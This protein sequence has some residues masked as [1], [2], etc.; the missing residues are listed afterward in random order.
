M[1]FALINNTLIDLKKIILFN[2]IN[3]WKIGCSQAS[4]RHYRQ[5]RS[6]SNFKYVFFE[7]IFHALSP[8]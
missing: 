6:A 2:R 7:T 5:T 4:P 3:S 1:Y 8:R